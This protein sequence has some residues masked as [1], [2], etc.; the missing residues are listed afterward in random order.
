[1]TDSIRDLLPQERFEEPPEVQV[2]KD[3]VLDKFQQPVK[4]TI[5]PTQIIIT[6]SS[7]ALAGTLRTYLHK[8]QELCQT[9]KRLVIRIGV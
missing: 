8:L 5:Q 7:A 6:V 9:E 3:F 4:V 2:I 1:M